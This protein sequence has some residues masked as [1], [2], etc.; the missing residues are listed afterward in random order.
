MRC[1]RTQRQAVDITPVQREHVNATKTGTLRRRQ[2]A[3]KSSHPD[4][5]PDDFAVADRR[6][7]L[8]AGA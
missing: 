7:D 5:E 2:Q 6:V 3:L 8:Q 4:I 1:Q